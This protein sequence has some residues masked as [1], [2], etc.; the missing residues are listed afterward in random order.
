VE[1]LGRV[2]QDVLFLLF[3]GCRVGGTLQFEEEYLL[4]VAVVDSECLVEVSQVPWLELQFFWSYLGQAL[5]S[6]H[7]S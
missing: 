5:N 1:L 6:S 2:A 3:G 4:L 7:R